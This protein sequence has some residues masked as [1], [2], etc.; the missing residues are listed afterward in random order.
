[1]TSAEI[2]SPTL[3][4][5]LDIMTSADLP[6]IRCIEAAKAIIEYEAPS[7]VFD[8]T[9][10]FL[11]GIAQNPNSDVGLKLEALKL[12]RKVEARRVVPG[13]AK[14][15]TAKDEAYL[16]KRLAA[17]RLRLRFVREGKWPGAT[18]WTEGIVQSRADADGIA[19]RLE[20]TLDRSAS[21]N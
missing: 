13:T 10:Q 3:A 20:R 9:Q 7:G 19:H 14:A 17:A 6:E 8:L 18:D 4:A 21:F 16:S 1:M 2:I 12:T 11:L 15:V 5:L